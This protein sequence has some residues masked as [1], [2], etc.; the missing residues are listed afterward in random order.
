M[1]APV[2]KVGSTKPLPPP[3]PCTHS[4]WQAGTPLT[5]ADRWPWLECLAAVVQR[6]LSEGRPAVLS[7]SALKPEYRWKL[8]GSSTTAGSGGGVAFVSAVWVLVRQ[9]PGSF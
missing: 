6:H 9:Q 3:T 4:P 5:D 2:A 8:R 7:C 1:S